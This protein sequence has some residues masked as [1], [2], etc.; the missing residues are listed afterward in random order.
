MYI[1][2]MVKINS[3]AILVKP[4]NSRNDAKLVGVYRALMLCLK[5]AG[6]FPKKH[7]LHNEVYKAMKTVI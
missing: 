2:V 3:N 5:W 6:N 7:V 4:I 1:I